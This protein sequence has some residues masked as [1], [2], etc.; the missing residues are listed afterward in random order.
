VEVWI[1]LILAPFVK[2]VEMLIC[3]PIPILNLKKIQKSFGDCSNYIEAIKSSK[4]FVLKC[5]L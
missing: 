4:F 1:G 3:R 5:K 2:C